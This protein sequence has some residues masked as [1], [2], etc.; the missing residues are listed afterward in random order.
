[1]SSQRKII[2]YEH[3]FTEFYMEQNEKVQEKIEYVFMVIR[4]I[5]N[6]PKKFLTHMSGTYGLYETRVE[7]GSNIYRIF[8]CLVKAT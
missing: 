5:Q 7:Y 1:M 2:F 4:T 3:H 6:V 8:C